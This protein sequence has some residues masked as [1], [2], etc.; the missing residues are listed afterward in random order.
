MKSKNTFRE[1]TMTIKNK[2]E[3][4][5]TFSLILKSRLQNKHHI[6]FTN[7]SITY[8]TGQSFTKQFN[9][10]QND[11]ITYKTINHLINEVQR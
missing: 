9:H 2:K 5:G 6:N 8:K 1:L 7:N 3:K 11:S 10:L 4:A